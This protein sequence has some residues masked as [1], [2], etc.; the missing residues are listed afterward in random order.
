VVLAVAVAVVGVLFARERAAHEDTRRALRAESARAAQLDRDLTAVRAERADLEKKLTA[1]EAHVLSPEA[2]L[3]IANCVRAY[4]TAERVLEE[5]RSRGASSG[6][7]TFITPGAG[8]GTDSVAKLC[9][10]A[11]P[12]LAKLD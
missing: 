4:A 1:A 8:L 10:A 11:E 9:S 3:A 12:Y 2:K 6:S 5:A 7:V